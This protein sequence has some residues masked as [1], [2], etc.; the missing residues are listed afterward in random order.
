MSHPSKD[1]V[2][3]FIKHINVVINLRLESNR[4][5]RSMFK[6]WQVYQEQIVTG[7]KLREESDKMLRDAEYMLY[8]L[9]DK[10]LDNQRSEGA[11]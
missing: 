1:G 5:S 3:K 11:L 10:A 7:T 9:I 2:D 6:R 8:E 4:R